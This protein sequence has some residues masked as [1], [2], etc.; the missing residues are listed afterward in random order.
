MLKRPLVSAALLFVIGIFTAA[1]DINLII[2]ILLCLS[3]CLFTYFR[4]KNTKV[5]LLAVALIVAGI[6]RLG[7]AEEYQNSVIAKYSG[8]NAHMKL[9]VAEFSEG[10]R[11]TAYFKDGGRTHKVSLTVE[12][13]I[14]LSPGDIVEGEIT[15]HTPFK[16]RIRFPGTAESYA[17]NNVFLTASAESITK[18]GER[19]GGFKGVIF[20]LRV[21]MNNLGE[22]V[23]YGDDRAL[24]NAMIFG[25]KRLVSDELYLALQASGLNHI[26]VVSGMHLSVAIAFIT[27][28]IQKLFGKKR[29]GN[30][31]V[32]LGA[33]LLTLVTGAG[34]SVIRA[35][36]MCF[37]YVLS[38]ILRRDR[39]SATSLA[40]AVLVMT[41]VNPFIV[42]NVGFIL[43]VLSV[44]GIFL[45]N[46]KISEFL[47]KFMPS[48]L[49]NLLALSISAQIAVLPVAIYYFGTI[50]PYALL[51]NMLL[52]PIA[53]I[54]VV[55]GMI[56][57][58]V[59]PA[60]FVLP[61]IAPCL[62]FL[63]GIMTSTCFAVKDFDGSLIEFSGSFIIF[64]TIWIFLLI[65]IRIRPFTRTGRR[66]LAAGFSAI[67]IFLCLVP[68]NR[69][70][71]IYTIPYG[72]QSITAIENADGN[73]LLID[74]PAFYDM[75]R[76]ENPKTPFSSVILTSSSVGQVF[77]D[78]SN[79]ER[80]IA[81]EALF[82]EKRKQRV[83]ESARKKNIHVEFVKDFQKVQ[84]GDFLVE[85]IAINGMESARAVKIEYDTK[86][87]ITLQG[88]SEKE[89][90]EM[91]KAG[92]S[93]NSDYII[94]PFAVNGYD[95]N[96]FTG[97]ILK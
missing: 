16:S 34:A 41:G 61:F 91:E 90:S 77:K 94:L 35:F 23:F 26:A 47:L 45:F 22:N 31:F 95:E 92:V 10:N 97:K 37:L 76:I 50:A 51:S 81:S 55:L 15:L 36:I 44:M 25:D 24:F 33:F 3:V 75:K 13:R 49:A 84:I 42:F 87:L 83:I 69:G 2:R 52:V 59:S 9:T 68:E 39:D 17:G 30:V 88:F 21:Y 1:Y 29:I 32:L 72:K 38:Q 8:R 65:L 18:T 64:A 80:L 54:Y 14:E 67:I 27:G 93:F 85:Y 63:S 20:S 48:K 28:L 86:T 73:S 12:E 62:K 11:I 7:L 66:R 78:K 74:C 82:S 96:L 5:S 43:S 6:F 60:A 19:E 56:Y 46:D 53:G 57:I 71:E 40:F 58:L 4:T 89:I 79:L 70:I